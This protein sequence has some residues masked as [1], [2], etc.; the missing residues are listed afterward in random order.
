M[1]AKDLKPNKF[2]P[3]KISEDKK[4]SLA[5][6]LNEFGDL[7]VIVF[8][9]RTGTL[10]SGHQRTSL[11]DKNSKVVIEK[12]FEKATE[13]GTLAVGFIES[14]N[15]ER[16]A[17][18][19]VDWDKE[20]ETEALLSA[21]KQGGEWDN[22]NLRILFAEHPKIR[23]DYTG[24]EIPELQMRDI[25]ITPPQIKKVEIAKILNKS[26]DNSQ[27]DEQYVKENKGPAEEADRERLPDMINRNYPPKP[28]PEPV[29]E[30]DPKEAF[31]KVKENTTPQGR[32]IVIII[33][34][35]TDEMKSTIKDDIKARVE[36]LGGKFF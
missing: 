1:K 33:K 17:Y 35:E 6:S 16:F 25:K 9:K 22:E 36:E 32:Q 8:N 34:C 12:K 3:R 24:F 13:T 7:G 23:V 19:E 28:E 21:N 30:I 27:T 29:T 14:E 20:K 11:M 2:N 15:G 10:V 4:K 31:A 26:E 5:R 18:R